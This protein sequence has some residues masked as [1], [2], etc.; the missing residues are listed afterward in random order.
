MKIGVLASGRGSNCEA[1]LIA[2]ERGDL[3]GE[4]VVLV[5]DQPAAPVL[6]IARQHNIE[7]LFLDP[8]KFKTR[9]TEETEHNYVHEMKKRGVKLICL[10]GF[11]RILKDHFLD[12]FTVLN[13]HPSLLP[14]FPGLH[15]QQKALE[16][17]VKFTGCTVHFVD[18]GIDTGPII[19]Q[20]VVPVLD[21]DTVATLSARI[22]KE[23]HRIYWQAVNLVVGGKIRIE[24]RRV[25]EIAPKFD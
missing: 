7:A 15:V 2:Q 24:N 19:K 4:I 1:L 5:S 21:D 3:M 16:Y 17:G 13:I 6:D 20:A 8:G 18:K 12:N 9:L 22:L 25:L 11:M 10:A 14:A 23:E